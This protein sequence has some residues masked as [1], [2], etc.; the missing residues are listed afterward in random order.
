MIHKHNRDPHKALRAKRVPRKSFSR[1]RSGRV[2]WRWPAD[3]LAFVAD[4]PAA[5]HNRRQA[6][7]AWYMLNHSYYLPSRYEHEEPL[8]LGPIYQRMFK[9]IMTSRGQDRPK[10]AG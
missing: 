5:P 1:P 2:S 6:E 9:R 4:D 8:E 3:I 10:C 7:P